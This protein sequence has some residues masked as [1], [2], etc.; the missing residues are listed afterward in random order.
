[1]L[2]SSYGSN[3][4]VT[5]D[6]VVSTE[7]VAVDTERPTAPESVG[8]DLQHDIDLTV[9]FL[10]T[11]DAETGTDLLDEPEQW[12]A[13]CRARDLGEAPPP[14][15]AR[16]VRDAMRASVSCTDAASA[17]TT[18]WPEWPMRMVL[19]G[20]VPVLT[21][22]DALGGVLAAAFNLVATG[23]WWRIKICPAEDCLWA[24]YDRSR[25]RSRTWCSMRVCGNR[26]KARSWRE[27]HVVP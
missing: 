27:R 15:S 17:E 12:C 13:W 3:P 10:N 24:F 22:N 18:S 20:G 23:H 7:A 1:M 5:Y 16:E 9:A 19:R 25:N 8:P 26:E 11:R 6:G 2:V 14:R 4:R 21:G